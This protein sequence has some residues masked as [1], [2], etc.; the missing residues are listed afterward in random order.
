[1]N[2]SFST[3]GGNEKPQERPRHRW[4]IDI[5]KYVG[6]IGYEHAVDCIQVSQDRT[7]K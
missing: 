3:Y 4:E 1:M 2:K 5:I 7:Q 6:G